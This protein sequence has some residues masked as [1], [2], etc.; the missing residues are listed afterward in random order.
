MTPSMPPI[1]MSSERRRASRLAYEAALHET[2]G[3]PERFGAAH[4]RAVVRL[5]PR[6]P[7]CG[8]V[9]CI[10]ATRTPSRL[11]GSSCGLATS[12]APL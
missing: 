5:C 6:R 10:V 11:P 12:L 3:R 9:R 4:T 8:V 1:R 7:R 2:E